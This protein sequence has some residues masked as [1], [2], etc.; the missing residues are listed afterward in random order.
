MTENPERTRRKQEIVE[1]AEENGIAET[2]RHFQASYTTV[3]G[4]CCEAKVKPPSGR[5]SS[6]GANAFQ[7]LK[8]ILDGSSISQA[9]KDLGVTRQ[10]AWQIK[11]KAEA[12]GFVF[13]GS[14][15][16]GRSEEA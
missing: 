7:I 11:Q 3:Y 9:A 2:C 8:R 10:R 14:Q 4:Y 6:L 1:Y 13:N 16:Q 15:C 5:K 12:A